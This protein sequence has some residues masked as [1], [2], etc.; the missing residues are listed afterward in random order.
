[1]PAAPTVSVTRPD[2]IAVVTI[3]APP[4]NTLGREARTELHAALEALEHDDSVRGVVLVGGGRNFSA[5]ADLA[6]FDSGDA[7]A[8]PSLHLT[9]TGVLDTLHAPSVAAI[10]GAALGGGLELALACS[11]RVAA[12]DA[13]LGLPETTLG[14]MPGAGGTQ[15]LPRLIGV[16]GALELIATGRHVSG[17]DAAALGLVDQLAEDPLAAA[18]ELARTM[19]DAGTWTRV[20]DLPIDDPLAPALIDLARR[21]AVRGR[22]P[23]V[24][25]ALDGIRA[26]VEL[27]FDEGLAT[28]LSLFQRLAT[29]PEASAARYRFLSERPGGGKG[30]LPA[31]TA[32]I[33]GGTMG[34][35]IA[36]AL[37][38]AGFPTTLIETDQERL[39]AAA[40]AITASLDD[41]VAKGRL[42]A[43]SRDQQLA[44]FTPAVGLT[45]AAGA[46][47]VIEAV[48]ED[49]KV[50]T[51]VFRELDAIAKPGAVL[52]SN[53]S[54]LDLDHIAAVTARRE[55][56]VGMHFFSPANI[57]KL[58]EV[59][60]G[61]RT[62]PDVLATAIAVSRRMG[63][64]PVVAKV[65]PGFIGNRIFDAYLRQ[66]NQLLREGATPQQIDG[67]L[68]RWG[69]A[70]GP[71]AVLDLVGNDVPALARKERGETDGAWAVADEV[72]ERGWLG[73]KSGAGWYRYAGGKPTPNPDLDV[74]L[75]PFQREGRG[76][77]DDEIVRRCILAMAVEAAA[78]LAD[79]VAASSRDVDTVMVRGYG[80]PAE[81]GGPWFFAAHTGWS[82]V[83]AAIRGFHAATGDD[84]W[85][86]PAGFTT[87]VPA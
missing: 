28:E 41:S 56:V 25:S 9:I 33:G 3:D 64:L 80:F 17:E 75:A 58:V 83:E 76:M 67:A 44:A 15:R 55:S 74:L 66:A 48:F 39:D 19:A 29:T 61:D 26:A 7:L 27:P 59:V 5:G 47:L 60:D 24:V 40:A 87:E 14:F 71:F 53:T 65:G 78:V 16:E 32:V 31:T 38:G 2:D 12:P 84:F 21:E 13:R 57:M 46:D 68:E 51:D 86:V 8:E 69:M 18:I 36:L 62:D 11:A 6:E 50:K 77:A 70:M 35:G 20:R 43:A 34:R 4:V 54:S 45:A 72:A 79:G 73:R 37:L 85:T 22:K 81:R 23:G 1:M 10:R 82:R 30:E 52:A 49:L 42:P 63:K